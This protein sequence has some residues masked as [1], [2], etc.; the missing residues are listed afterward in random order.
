MSRGL[1]RRSTRAALGACLLLILV[2]A[3]ISGCD[4]P[5]NPPAAPVSGAQPARIVSL[6]PSITETLFAVGAGDRV[7]GVTAHCDYPAEAATREKVG[8]Y[9]SPSVEAV[10]R[11]SPDLVIAPEEGMLAAAVGQLRR[12]G[13]RVEA[14]RVAS[15]DDLYAAVERIG[16]LAGREGAGRALAAD[17]RRRTAAV[18]A[19]VGARP[20]VR[21]LLV[22]DHDPTIA[23]G[24]GTFGDALLAAAGAANVAA[25]ATSAYPQLSSEAILALAP[26]AIVDASM[27]SAPDAD[28]A[29]AAR[30]RY[31]RIAAV[32]AVRD[33]RILTID[34]ELLVRPGPRL[35]LG[36]ERL[37]RGLHPEAFE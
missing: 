18:G 14:V 35:V 23:A 12:V 5:T 8:G 29:A 26:D 25:G 20:R 6:A 7:V 28:R 32:P 10:L 37:A 1:R 30:E 27:A 34:P 24:P 15:L 36:L 17:L 33:G 21:A 3:L 19:A 16:A 4:S 9:D 2:V 11:L 13:V 31:A 22:V